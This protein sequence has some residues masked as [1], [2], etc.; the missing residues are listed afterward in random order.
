MESVIAE[1]ERICDLALESTKINKF[2]TDR[3]LKAKVTDAK[4]VKDE[5]LRH[6]QNVILEIDAMT[7]Y[8]LRLIDAIGSLQGNAAEIC[9]KCLIAR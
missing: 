1:S 2:A 6:R 3:E 8:K 9:Q 5:L 7:T 4:F